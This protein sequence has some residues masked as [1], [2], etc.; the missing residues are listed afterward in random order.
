MPTLTLGQSITFPHTSSGSPAE[1][2]G[3][4]GGGTVGEASSQ[5]PVN[6]DVLGSHPACVF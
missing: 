4:T 5:Q 1:H 2:W 3:G 6:A